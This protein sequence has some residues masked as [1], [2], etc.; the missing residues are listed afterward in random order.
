MKIRST[1]LVELVR[2]YAQEV[3]KHKPI[4][5]VERINNMVVHRLSNAYHIDQIHELEIDGA[6][7]HENDDVSMM[8]VFDASGYG[9]EVKMLYQYAISPSGKNFC[10][11]V[12]H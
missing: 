6:T 10:N 12:G 3:N 1:Q 11:Y 2:A 4:S 7:Y 9:D 5:V 8:P